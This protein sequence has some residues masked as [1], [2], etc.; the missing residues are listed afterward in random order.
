MKQRSRVLSSR[1]YAHVLRTM[2]IACV[3]LVVS[4][5]AQFLLVRRR[6]RP[7]KGK[8]WFPGGRILKL[9]TIIR[10]ARRKLKEETGIQGG[11]FGSVLTVKETIFSDSEFGTT[12]HS[13][14]VVVPVHLKKLP[15]RIMTPSGFHA[16]IRL[17]QVI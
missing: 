13:V 11:V 3:D 14:N 12:T 16:L 5:R 2:P 8:W 7:A 9:E 10:A 17:G 1:E 6:N 15:K 4:H